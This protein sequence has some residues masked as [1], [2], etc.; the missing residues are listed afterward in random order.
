MTA[1]NLLNASTV[2]AKSTGLV[3]GTGAASNVV[4]NSA[5]SSTLVKLN[6]WNIANNNV[7]VATSN[8][9]LVKSTGVSYPLIANVSVPAGTALVAWGKDTV[10]YL[11][12]GDYINSNASVAFSL[13]ATTSYEIIS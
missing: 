4:I 12:E 11:E 2:T 13:V 10:V 3:L 9:Y 6:S 7:N 5:G 1:P 8:V